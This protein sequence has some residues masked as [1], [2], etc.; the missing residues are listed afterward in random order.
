[1]TTI[2]VTK[3]ERGKLCGFGEKHQKSYARFRKAIDNLEYGELLTLDFWFPRNARRHRKHFAM[4]AVIF[5]A[6]E[7]FDDSE[8]MRMWLQI[9]AGHCEYVPGMDGEICAIPR[10]IAWSKMDDAEFEAHH[11]AVKD[12]LRTEHAR[13]FLW[14]HLSEAQSH[15][16]VETI[17][18]EF[19]D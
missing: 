18:R 5:D 3:N 1:M 17:L 13:A 16:M 8:Q 14:P 15:E 9:G 19:D 2:I 4:L 7:R 10:S 6:Q 11:R 12:F